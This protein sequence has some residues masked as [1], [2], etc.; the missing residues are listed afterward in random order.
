[1]RNAY[2]LGFST[3]DPAT[4]TVRIEDILNVTR[5]NAS[6]P[7]GSNVPYVQ[8]FGLDRY[9]ATESDPPDGRI[10]NYYLNWSA[11]IERG[12]LWMPTGH[13]FAPPAERVDVWTNGAFAFS[14][15]ILA[16][17]REGLATFIV[18]LLN[19]AE[20]QDA[21]QYIIKATVTTPAP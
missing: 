18:D 12:I 8:I 19:P 4:L 14:G 17:V 9:G 21:H 2:N 20:E 11:D 16:P 10:D 3:I 5:T 1:M 15:R 7:E 13:G 6:H